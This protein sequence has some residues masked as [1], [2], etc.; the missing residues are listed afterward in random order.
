MS[1][2]AEIAI[3][4]HGGLKRWREFNRL[5]ARQLVGGVLWPM[6]SHDAIINDA[7]I[8]VELHHEW[9]SHHPFTKG[10]LHSVFEPT[11][12]AI[13]SKSGGVLY[14][15]HNPR[16]SFE[17]HTR[18]TPWDVLQLAYFAGYAM[19][20]YLTT[21]FLFALP[22]V[23]SEEIDPWQENGATW[24]CLR[25]TFPDTIATHCKQQDF[26]FDD[27]GLLQRHDYDVEIAGSSPA[28]HYVYNHNVIDGIIVPMS[29]RVFIRQPDNRPLDEPI[30]VS[31][32]L[33]NVTF[34]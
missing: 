21:P 27:S 19:W 29:H 4:A 9:A 28:A 12:V 8:T 11:R 26:Y 13:E 31:L 1:K 7:Q 6:K 2:L 23:E 18:E 25:V 17:G 22:G 3:N 32:D 14:E 34:S 20:T 5:S 15:R 30:I 10:D 33:E 24:R 16:D